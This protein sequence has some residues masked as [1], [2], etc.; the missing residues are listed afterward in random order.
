MNWRDLEQG[1]P[2]IA[3]LALG[4]FE[5][6]DMALV[7]TVRRDGSPRISCVYPLVLDG[8]L[9]LAMMWR[10]RKAVDLLRDPRLAL[11]NAIA[12]NRGDEVEVKLYGRASEVE[13]AQVKARYLDAVPSWGERRFHLFAVELE[14]A[15]VVRYESGRQRVVVW[16]RGL[17]FERPY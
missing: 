3:A 10:S 7:G 11:H 12:T 17:E 2:E 8:E 16:P 15:A 6:A 14:S 5:A 13:D 4:Q 9:Y 1:A